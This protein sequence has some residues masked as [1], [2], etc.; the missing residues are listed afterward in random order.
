MRQG[1]CCNVLDIRERTIYREDCDILIVILLAPVR[2]S[3]ILS[4]ILLLD[5]RMNRREFAPVRP[6]CWIGVLILPGS[7]RH[8]WLSEPGSRGHIGMKRDDVGA[9]F[10]RPARAR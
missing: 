3:H 2:M 4:G 5:M 10:L 6:P 9:R 8:H 7:S 1:E